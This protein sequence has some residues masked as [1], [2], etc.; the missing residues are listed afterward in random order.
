MVAP[1]FDCNNNSC[2]KWK[3]KSSAHKRS[4]QL[5][6]IT[7]SQNASRTMRVPSGSY[8]YYGKLFYRYKC[9]YRHNIHVHSF[10]SLSPSSFHLLYPLDYCF[11]ITTKLMAIFIAYE[12]KLKNPRNSY[13]PMLCSHYIII[14][15]IIYVI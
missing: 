11:V 12:R 8:S 15:Y 14:P 9:C 2:S 6:H 7:H 4:S 1:F 5:S 10:L 3:W 13:V